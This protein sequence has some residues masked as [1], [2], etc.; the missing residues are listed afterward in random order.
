[1]NTLRYQK[2]PKQ[3]SRHLVL[4]FRIKAAQSLIFLKFLKDR[5]ESFYFCES[6]L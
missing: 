2:L 6:I 1:M 5:M 4:L 3:T